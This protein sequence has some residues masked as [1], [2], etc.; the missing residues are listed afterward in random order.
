MPQE[1]ELPE[2]YH[3]SELVFVGWMQSLRTPHIAAGTLG[4]PIDWTKISNRLV[5]TKAIGGAP[6]KQNL[7]YIIVQAADSPPATS[8]VI[9]T[10]LVSQGYGFTIPSWPDG[11]RF[12]V[13]SW[14]FYALL[15][16]PVNKG[17]AYL[18]A[19][20]KSPSDR[21]HKNGLGHK[22]LEY[23]DIS[24]GQVPDD[25]EWYSLVHNGR[26]L[27]RN[28]LTGEMTDKEPEGFEEPNLEDWKWGFSP[29]L[30]WKVAS[31]RPDIVQRARTNEQQW[32]LQP[33]ALNGLC[34]YQGEAAGYTGKGKGRA[35]YV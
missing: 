33:L 11:A 2:I 10:C 8:S 21:P 35:P 29:T 3:W 7:N 12:H 17:I 27:Y 22:V 5:T 32:S 4:K 26:T 9:K 15:D 24:S 6:L 23:V 1:H 34:E 16:L 19:Q 31:Y 28:R 20:H 13:G 14:C 25:P 30:I 18:L